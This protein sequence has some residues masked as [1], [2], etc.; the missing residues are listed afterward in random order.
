MLGGMDT[1][2]SILTAHYV[3]EASFKI[4][5]QAWLVW[6]LASLAIAVIVVGLFGVYGA[7][8]GYKIQRDDLPADIKLGVSKG[9]QLGND[10]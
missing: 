2:I 6:L 4:D 5:A 9:S 10:R 7:F 1:I 3:I 8:K